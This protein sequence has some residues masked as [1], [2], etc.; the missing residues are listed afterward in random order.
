MVEVT[1]KTR[2]LVGLDKDE[3]EEM[4]GMYLHSLR[5]RKRIASILEGK[6][7]SHFKAQTNRDNYE[8]ANWAYA[9]ADAMGYCRALQEVISLITDEQ[10][11][12][13]KK[14]GRPPTESK[15]PTPIV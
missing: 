15:H 13:E 1:I 12:E 5:L 3:K 14:R 6:R 4:R 2:L 7:Q 10:K 11:D 8:T 9:Q